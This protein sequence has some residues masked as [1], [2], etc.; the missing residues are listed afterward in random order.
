MEHQVIMQEELYAESE[1]IIA[2]AQAL[3]N[4]VD[5]PL[6]DKQRDFIR[7]ILANTEKFIHLAAAFLS[8]PL[9]QVS[10]DMRHDLGNPLTPIHGYSELLRMRMMATM[11]PAQ[12]SH[13]QAIHD[14]TANIRHLVD[15]LV[16]AAREAAAAQ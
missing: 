5:G 13:V 6:D 7:I 11:T 4:E 2:H 8:V 12:Q 14:S 3:L 10:Q 15:Q 9:A 1:K 16:Q